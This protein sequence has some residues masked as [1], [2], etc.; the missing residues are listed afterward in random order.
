MVAHKQD[1][2]SEYIELFFERN[3]QD[4]KGYLTLEEMKEFLRIVVDLNYTK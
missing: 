1:L 4:Q 3:D 2:R